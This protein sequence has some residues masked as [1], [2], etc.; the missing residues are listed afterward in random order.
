MMLAN[1]EALQYP[2]PQTQELLSFVRAGADHNRSLSELSQD[3][4]WEAF[5]GRQFCESIAGEVC[6]VYIGRLGGI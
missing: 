1:L 5:L 6:E 3:S 4:G 2:K